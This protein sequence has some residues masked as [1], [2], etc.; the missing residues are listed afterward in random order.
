MKQTE[1][2]TWRHLAGPRGYEADRCNSAQSAA[3]RRTARSAPP[4]S[5]W[6]Y[7]ALAAGVLV[8]AGVYA[9]HNQTPLAADV[10]GVYQTAFEQD[11]SATLWSTVS[12]FAASHHIQLPS[13]L[14]GTG[15]T[16]MH[17]P[18]SGAITVTQD[19]QAN[20]PEM[21]LTGTPGE[22][23]LAAGSGTVTR[24]QT[25]KSG[26]FITIDHGSIG[27]SWYTG[28]AN[29]TVHVNE[30]VSAGEVIGSLPTQTKHPQLQFALEKNNQFENP[31][32]FI[33]FPAPA[34]TGNSQ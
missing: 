3:I 25:T 30:Y 14:P 20:E 1:T 12:A 13:F 4:G 21:V 24:V 27:T 32:D 8:A 5:T 26:T 15:A 23:V 19:Y 17:V 10:R 28:V 16:V 22:H 29:P 2:G 18:L 11:D 34:K 7:Q 6:F 31:H 33:H 9:M